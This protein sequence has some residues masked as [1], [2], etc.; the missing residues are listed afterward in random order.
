VSANPSSKNPSDSLATQL[1]C[2]AIVVVQKRDMF[3][4]VADMVMVR[5]KEGNQV[6]AMCSEVMEA[7]T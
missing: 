2:L 3:W 4:Q 6:N 5:F 1:I 7:Q